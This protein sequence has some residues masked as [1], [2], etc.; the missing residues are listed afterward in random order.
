MFVDH[1]ASYCG[2]SVS[3]RAQHNC[4]NGLDFEN[5]YCPSVVDMEMLQAD[6]EAAD[7]QASDLQT[8]SHKF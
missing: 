7:R 1:E 6:I 8:K 4:A 3:M 2:E 5:S